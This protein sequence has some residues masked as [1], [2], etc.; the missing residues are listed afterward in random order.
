[1][2][3]PTFVVLLAVTVII[4]A[5]GLPAEAQPHC[6]LPVA[7]YLSDGDGVPLEGTA[8]VELRFYAEPG[9]AAP[10]TEC[11]SFDD[12][13]IDS[14]WLRVTVDG[15]EAPPAGDCGVVPLDVL[16]AGAEGLWVGVSVGGTELGPRVPIGAVPFSVRAGNAD[17]L[18]GR[19]PEAFE[20]AGTVDTHAAGPD[21]HHSSTS[22]G[23]ALT[24]SSVTVGDTVLE[25]GRVDLGASAA[26]ELT[27]TIVETL[28][29]GGE[30]DALHGHASGGAPGGSCY[31]AWG[32]TTCGGEFAAMYTGV[33]AQM[34]Q[35]VAWGGTGV[36]LSS[37][38]PMCVADDGIGSFDVST[39][40]VSVSEIVVGRDG[41]ERLIPAD[42][43]LVCAMCCQ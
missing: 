31:V 5:T 20:A 35:Y 14:G 18:Q 1:M 37:V 15:C 23:I 32:V 29:G 6:D 27:A 13:I 39:S 7:A 38:G 25:D 42:E 2:K 34:T 4:V 40:D 10:P 26:D 36:G 8:D 24:P 17:T 11:R 41:R 21:A 3:N 19:G 12:A 16:F 28:T 9:P 22:D 30:A 43:R 33:A